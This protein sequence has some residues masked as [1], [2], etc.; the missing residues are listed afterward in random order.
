MR[1]ISHAMPKPIIWRWGS[2]AFNLLNL[3][4]THFHLVDLSYRMQ[5][6]IQNLSLLKVVGTLART[7]Y[8]SFNWKKNWSGKYFAL[9]VESSMLKPLSLVPRYNADDYQNYTSRGLCETN[10]MGYRPGFYLHQSMQFLSTITT[11]LLFVILR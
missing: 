11:F 2:T 4:T 1:A 5:R 8:Q 10:C 6:K 7:K 3:R 9:F